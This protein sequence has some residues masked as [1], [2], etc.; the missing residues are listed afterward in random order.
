MRMIPADIGAPLIFATLGE[1]GWRPVQVR[2]SMCKALRFCALSRP[3]GTGKAV[4]TDL[5]PHDRRTARVGRPQGVEGLRLATHT[6]DQ[7]GPADIRAGP[8]PC[9]HSGCRRQQDARSAYP[10]TTF[11]HLQDASTTRPIS[12]VR[13]STSHRPTDRK[14]HRAAPSGPDPR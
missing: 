3:P 6:P 14:V 5:E 2:T 1:G 7:R 13:A 12:P 9:D 8:V 11:E 4:M 10:P